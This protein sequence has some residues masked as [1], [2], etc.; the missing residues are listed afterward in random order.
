MPTGARQVL[1]AYAGV[2]RQGG[3]AAGA[4]CRAPRVHGDGATWCVI[5]AEHRHVFPANAGA[6]KARIVDPRAHMARLPTF[7]AS[8]AFYHLLIH[9]FAGSR[10]PT[11]CSTPP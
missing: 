8:C 4:W 5:E 2:K 3:P 9:F 10:G 11:S 6:V 1:P 7:G